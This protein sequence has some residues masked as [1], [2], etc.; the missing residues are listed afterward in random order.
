MKNCG[1]LGILFDT[2]QENKY[3]M[4]IFREILGRFGF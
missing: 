4:E 1:Y 2:M 3:I